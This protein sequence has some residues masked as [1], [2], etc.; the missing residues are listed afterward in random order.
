MIDAY[1]DGYH[2]AL[3]AA[4]ATVHAFEHFG[5]YQGD[6]WAKVTIAERTG[7]VNGSFGSCSHCDA[8][9]SEFRWNDQEKPDYRERL[10]A[11]GREYLEKMLD[12]SEAEAE[13]ARN[14]EW[15]HDAEEMLKFIK[16]NA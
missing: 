7:W 9:E 4:G 14:I 11:F 1:K 12:Q 15:D 8:F 5:S 16:A 13:A 3:E 10:A 2:E 6:W